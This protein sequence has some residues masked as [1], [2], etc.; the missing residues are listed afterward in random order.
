[1][2]RSGLTIQEIKRHLIASLTALYGFPE[3]ASI[4]R[5]ILEHAGYPEEEILLYPG[6]IPSDH[7]VDQINKI[8]DQIHKNQPVQYVL[9]MTEFLGISLKVRPGVLI[10]RQET[11]LL[12]HSV[13]KD[14]RSGKPVIADLGTGSGCIAIALKNSLPGAT[15][16]GVDN[17]ERALEVAGENAA[18]NHTE[19][20]LIRADLLKIRE[21]PIPGKIDLLVSNPPYVT[22]AEK[23]GMHVRVTNHEPA[24]ALFV[25]GNDP[26]IFYRLIAQLAQKHLATGGTIWVEINEAFGTETCELFREYGFEK[27]ELIRDLQGK[28]RIIKASAHE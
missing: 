13:L 2:L 9:G 17:S 21:L 5:L 22:P 7:R 16:Y 12:V 8:T 14:V 1:M 27:T 3:A 10:P 26:L 28:D 15:V 11:E 23:A 19:V 25:P 6:A 24:S 18:M 4:T 20:H